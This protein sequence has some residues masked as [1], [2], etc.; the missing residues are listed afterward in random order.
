MNLAFA[1]NDGDDWGDE[2]DPQLPPVGGQIKA[3]QLSPPSP[4]S[5]V[6][7]PVEAVR[8]EPRRS[9]LDVQEKQ[10]A[11]AP[12][13]DPPPKMED[14]K[15]TPQHPPSKIHRNTLTRYFV[16]KSNNH[17]NLVLSIENNVWA[18]QRH[19]EDKFTEALRASPHVILIFSVNN[20]GGFQGY[21]KMVGLPG[22]SRKG[23]VFKDYG[24]GAFDVKWLRLDDLE[25]SV[26][27]HIQNPW[28]E[29]KSVKISRDGQELPFEVGRELCD[30][31]D[32]R[33]FKNNPE[34]FKSDKDEPELGGPNGILNKPS[35]E[36]AFIPPQLPPPGMAPPAYPTP[37]MGYTLAYPHHPGAPPMGYHPAYPPHAVPPYGARERSPSSGSSS[38][39]SG[40]R[41]KQPGYPPGYA[42]GYPQGYP[43]YPPPH[44]MHGV[45]PPRFS[46]P[47]YPPMM[48]G[49]PPPGY[50]E[51]PPKESSRR[52]KHRRK[53]SRSR[54]RR[55][56]RSQKPP[57][58]KAPFDASRAAGP[59]LDW[60]G[61]DI[62]APP[63][64]PAVAPAPRPGP[65]ADWLGPSVQPNGRGQRHQ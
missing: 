42:P 27:G 55:R 47:G 39:D 62:G 53:K 30:M 51:H 40:R 18:T 61:P 63:P 46:P 59:P 65:P 19:N 50:A 33:V 64:R 22:K 17:K 60:R 48:H 29:N 34:E 38:S 31:I 32:A 23:S 1:T 4:P 43:G 41:Q 20:S 28:N 45:P 6:K 44:P 35:T 57:D 8:E 24:R 10:L 21:A 5:P 16:I 26:C 13:P 9:P 7:A 11:P 56:R 52:G 14:P 58:F 36:G 15:P 54:T 37:P 12:A 3:D 25:F 2:D 49:A